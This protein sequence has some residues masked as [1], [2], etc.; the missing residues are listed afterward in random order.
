MPCSG[1]TILSAV[2]VKPLGTGSPALGLLGQCI[3]AGRNR[4]GK[5]VWSPARCARWSVVLQN[6]E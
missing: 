3:G 1:N 6:C 2:A 5:S 4:K